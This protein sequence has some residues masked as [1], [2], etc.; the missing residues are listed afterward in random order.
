MRIFASCASSVVII[1][2]TSAGACGRRERFDTQ[3]KKETLPK[4]GATVMMEEMKLFFPSW[5]AGLILIGL[6]LTG[7]AAPAAAQ[8]ADP[9]RD[10][11]VAV[12][13]Q[14]MPAVVN[15]A[16][17]R[18]DRIRNETMFSAGSGVVIDE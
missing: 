7:S 2:R 14:V 9:R 4:G 16:T 12:I 15:I 11:T 6:A 1:G 13:E 8:E 3:Q 10:A 18:P 17:V 5:S